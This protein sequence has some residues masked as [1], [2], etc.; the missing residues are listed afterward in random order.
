MFSHAKPE[1]QEGR[2]QKVASRS[3]APQA[4]QALL[5]HNILFDLLLPDSFDQEHQNN[6]LYARELGSLVG[7]REQGG[8]GTG[9]PLAL[10]ILL[11]APGSLQGHSGTRSCK[12]L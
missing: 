1:V 2:R 9:S 6:L 5:L 11:P 8:S 3:R 4:R 10:P 7:W 12:F